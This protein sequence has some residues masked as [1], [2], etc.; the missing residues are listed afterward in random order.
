MSMPTLYLT[1]PTSYLVV[2]HGLILLAL[3]IGNIVGLTYKVS[4]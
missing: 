1:N 2:V 4:T 3:Y